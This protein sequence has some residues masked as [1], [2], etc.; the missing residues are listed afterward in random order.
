MIIN[1]SLINHL[2]PKNLIDPLLT[3]IHLILRAGLAGNKS[4]FIND[5]LVAADRSNAVWGSKGLLLFSKDLGRIFD[6]YKPLGINSK[7]ISRLNRK[8][9]ITYFPLVNFYQCSIF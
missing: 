8:F 2:D 3:Q 7:A 9:L 6:F 1:K 4:L 5:Y